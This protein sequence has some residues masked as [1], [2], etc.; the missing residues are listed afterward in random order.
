MN[1][2]QVAPSLPAGAASS[3]FP[4]FPSSLGRFL[5]D[6]ITTQWV[7]LILVPALVAVGAVLFR[8]QA[9]K[10]RK[11]ESADKVVG[12][13]LGLTACLTL[14]VSGFVLVT[15][16]GAEADAAARQHYISGLF[17]VL[18]FFVG[19]MLFGSWLMHRYG[20]DDSSPPKSVGLTPWAINLGGLLYLVIAF[21]VTGGAFK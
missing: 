8:R 11:F 3:P 2:L 16:K 6:A 13:D 9:R 21:V 1:K 10:V 20:W 18:A 5:E 7:V 14:L 15:T 19:I 12:F 4:E 17:V